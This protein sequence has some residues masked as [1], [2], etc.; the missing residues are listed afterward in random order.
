MSLTPSRH[1]VFFKNT[2]IFEKYT[3]FSVDTHI[4]SMGVTPKYTRTIAT[5]KN[6]QKYTKKYT[7]SLTK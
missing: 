2:C 3:V 4:E 5:F 6:T 1:S 7:S